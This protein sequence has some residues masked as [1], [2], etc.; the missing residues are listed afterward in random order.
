MKINILVSALFSAILVIGF[1]NCTS[2]SSDQKATPTDAA[3]PAGGG[4]SAVQ[5]D[6]SQ[7]DVVKVAVGSPDH[8]TLVAAVKAAELVDV[9][10]NAG[11]FTVFAPTNAAFDKLPPGTV[12]GLLKPDKKDALADV[13][14]YHVAVAVYK[15]E[16]LYDGQVI[17]MANDGKVTI[18][19]KDGKITV[20][21]ANIVASVPASNGIVHVIDE[22]L[23]QK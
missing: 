5:D 14:Q 6:V 1:T 4:Q 16:M 8:T 17:P 22:V 7:K 3:V 18:G 12:E 20:N 21:G 19:V 11:P 10:S 2:T 13:L 9:L 15:T 23:L